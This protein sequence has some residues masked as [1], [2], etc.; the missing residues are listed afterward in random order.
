MKLEY[1]S[2]PSSP[3]CWPAISSTRCS[4]PS[5]SEG[6]AMTANGWLQILVFS[7]R[8][9]RSRSRWAS[10]CTASS[11]ATGSRCRASSGRSSAL[12]YRALRRRSDARADLEAVHARAAGLQRVRP[13]GHLRH[14]AAAGR[15]A[16][17]PAGPRRPSSAD[18]SFN[19]A[20]SFTTNTNWQGYSGE[21]TMSY[22]TQMAGLAWHNFTSAAAGIGVAL[23][24]AR[25]L[26]APTGG[27]TAR[28]TLGNFWVDLIRGIAL[29]AAADQHRL[30]A[31]PGLAGR[32]PELQRPTSTSTTLEG[33]KQTI[34]HGAGRLA[35]G[36]QGARHQRRRLLQRQ[37]RRTRSR[38]RRRS[39]TSSRCS[40]IFAI[41]AGA[42]LHLRPDGARPAPG[43]GALRR[44]GDP[45]L[46]RRHRL[47][48]TAEAQR[49]PGHGRTSPRR[50]GAR[51]HGGQGGALRRRQLG[52]LR[53]RHHRRLVRRGQ[54]DARQLHAARRPGA[55]GQHPARRGDLRRRRRRPVR[56]AGLRAAR[57]LHRRPDGRAHARVPG[58][59]DRAARDEAGHAL[60]ADLP[61]A[62]S[63]ASPP[64]ARCADY[65][66][67]SLNNDGPH[68]LTEIL[69]AY[70]SGA[71][72]NGSAFAGLNA[73]TPWYNITLGHRPCWSA[74]S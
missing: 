35:G 18:S 50:S 60:R 7:R 5:V 61:A 2:A 72:N 23:A 34:A 64:G 41:S 26:H 69:Y 58:Q 74:A 6:R 43:L 10:T 56:H 19:T 55:A 31:R 59:E 47:P 17:Q 68:G 38:T 30:R 32:H 12:L 46:R 15:P 52:A 1:L 20:V 48:T 42:D 37:Q 36:D 33:G 14:P 45:V 57:G 39:P 25:G 22:L 70:T 62:S 65:G 8:S 11:K 3:S 13:A 29:R 71:G 28:K 49:Q 73:N 63:S 53:D 44:D 67:S 66:L 54:L 27:P 9:W 16:A 51:Q 40:L 21:S 24:L 4:S